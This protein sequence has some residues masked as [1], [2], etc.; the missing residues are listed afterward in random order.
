MP[1]NRPRGTVPGL[2]LLAGAA[3][4]SAGCRNTRPEVPPERPYLAPR[5]A[6]MTGDTSAPRVGFSTEPPAQGNALGASM[7]TMP[8]APGSPTGYGTAPGSAIAPPPDILQELPGPGANS[9][10]PAAP[11][12]PRGQMGIGNAPPSPL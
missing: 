11:M 12:P 7:G 4:L 6:G 5:G 9:V 2:A 8:G 1:M 3:L 10:P